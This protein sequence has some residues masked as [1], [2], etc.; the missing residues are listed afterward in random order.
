[1]KMSEDGT[2]WHVDD[3]PLSDWPLWRSTGV[4]WGRPVLT[5]RL[6]IICSQ[7]EVIVFLTVCVC[8]CVF[9]DEKRGVIC[10]KT[11]RLIPSFL[12]FHLFH[13]ITF[14]LSHLGQGCY[15]SS[16]HHLSLLLLLLLLCRWSVR[17]FSG[18]G[19]LPRCSGPKQG[20]R[21]RYFSYYSHLNY[22]LMHQHSFNSVGCII[23][24]YI[25]CH[26][27]NIR[28]D[29]QEVNQ[30]FCCHKPKEK[31]TFGHFYEH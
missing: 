24:V 31:T 11:T 27:N 1:M 18:P 21:C 26:T 29:N 19:F 7:K 5:L 2:R 13:F 17:R 10:I 12:P 4:S 16:R 30:R 20:S 15:S 3:T 14:V 6:P 8:V 25:S 28:H 9:A 23:V 22:I